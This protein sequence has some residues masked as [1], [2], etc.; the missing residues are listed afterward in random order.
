MIGQREL[1]KR[2][3]RQVELNR[4]PRVSIIIGEKGSGRKTL[5]NYIAGSLDHGLTYIAP[6]SHAIEHIL[7]LAYQVAPAVPM[8][9]V[10]TECD[11]ISE[12]T[13]KLL[14]YTIKDLPYEAYFI[15]TCENLN[16]IPL[17]IKNNAVTY[18]MESYSYEDK[19]DYLNNINLP[20]EEKEYIL[21]VATNIG[22]VKEM[23]EMNTKLLRKSIRDIL[24]ALKTN[25]NSLIDAYNEN[26]DR[27]PLH[28]LWRA[29]KQA[30]SEQA[31]IADNPVIYCRLMAIT[32]D[33]LQDISDT[34]STE[35]LFYEWLS[36]IENEW[37][38][39][40]A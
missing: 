8:L 28:I 17:K 7:K 31:Q 23:C 18:I 12:E 29:F 2:I 19:C 35:D 13:T 24:N 11:N 34:D 3:D 20:D 26:D 15:L 9:Y 39:F 4:F 10:L 22:E 6:T 1:L 25:E 27:F 32:G 5:A 38:A 37:S 14:L 33:Y 36:E 21:E 30:C 40:N 16:N